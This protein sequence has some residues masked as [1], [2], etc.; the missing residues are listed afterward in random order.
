ML[1]IEAEV[2]V[3][4]SKLVR[5]RFT[6]VAEKRPLAAVA[7]YPAGGS[8]PLHPVRGRRKTFRAS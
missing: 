3:L 5:V 2:K 1:V 6:N 4:A 7:A 8:V